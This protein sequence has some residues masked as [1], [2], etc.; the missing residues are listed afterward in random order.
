MAAPGAGARSYADDAQTDLN[1]RYIRIDDIL[2]TWELDGRVSSAHLEV[3]TSGDLTAVVL[4]TGLVD[5]LLSAAVRHQ[6]AA[7]GWI[8]DAGADP[9]AVPEGAQS[10]LSSLFQEWAGERSVSPRQELD[11]FR[12]LLRGLSAEE[13]DAPGAW[14]CNAARGEDRELIYNYRYSL[15]AHIIER[16]PRARPYLE[17]LL[18]APGEVWVRPA[19]RRP[20]LPT[21][22][23]EAFASQLRCARWAQPLIAEKRLWSEVKAA[24]VGAVVRAPASSRRAAP[25]S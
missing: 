25:A 7:A 22:G 23:L 8:L 10:L 20:D 4:R 18:S 1:A 11:L 19:E 6:P 16:G 2:A 14:A 24:W 17:E 3:L 15:A 12:R 13:R 5:T 9:R 21:L